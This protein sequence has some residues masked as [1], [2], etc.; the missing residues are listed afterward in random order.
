MQRNLGLVFS[1]THKIKPLIWKKINVSEMR[2][3][4]VFSFPL[5]FV[6]FLFGSGG[7]GVANFIDGIQESR[8]GLPRPLLLLWGSGM[9]F[10]REMLS[11][12][13]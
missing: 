10:V 1:T 7:R 5:F 9:E 2:L 4:K 6:L 8:E 13:G 11:V 3:G 12:G